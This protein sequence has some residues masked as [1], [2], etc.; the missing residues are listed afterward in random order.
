MCSGEWYE[1]LQNDD[2]GACN[3]S[4][5]FNGPFSITVCEPNGGKA[6]TY[7]YSRTRCG[8]KVFWGAEA[9]FDDNSGD[10]DNPMG[11]GGD[12]DDGDNICS[13]NDGSGDSDDDSDDDKA[14]KAQRLESSRHQC[15]VSVEGAVA[16]RGGHAR[17]EM[18]QRLGRRIAQKKKDD[19][20]PPEP[21]ALICRN[22]RLPHGHAEIC[23]C[24]LS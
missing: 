17:G 3:D 14:N 2:M 6:H 12:G 7:V 10:D 22:R 11:E 13:S 15:M 23:A 4:R 1:A 18:V 20:K 16:A 5:S 21:V 19:A 24:S 9:K 8:A